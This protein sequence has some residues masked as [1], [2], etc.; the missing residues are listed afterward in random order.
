MKLQFSNRNLMRALYLC[1]ALCGAILFYFIVTNIGTAFSWLGVLINISM[2]VVFGFAIAYFLRPL[3]R[4]FEVLF[5]KI[6]FGKLKAGTKRMFSILITYILVIV[7]IVLLVSFIAPQIA[8]SVVKLSN[9]VPVYINN[10]V[11]WV[12]DLLNDLL[13]KNIISRDQL[14]QIEQ[15]VKN[16]IATIG[17]WLTTALPGLVETSKQVAGTVVNLVFGFMLAIYVLIEKEKLAKQAK[18]VLNAFLPRRAAASFISTM[19]EADRIFG[20]YISSKLVEVIILGLICFVCMMLIGIP[21]AM[22]ISVIF[23]IS[24]LIPMFGAIIGAVP[25]TLL[26]LAINPLQA[27]WYILLVIVLGQFDGNIL[28]PKLLG[29]STGLSALLVIFSIFVGGGL[30]GIL[31]MFLAVPT[32][33]VLYMLFKR[34]VK[35]RLDKKNI[36][37]VDKNQLSF[38]DPPQ[39]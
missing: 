20:G 9:E 26:I 6:S 19:G 31:G 8:D 21:Y 28:G 24:N 15:Y 35:A 12:N 5:A 18:M 3:V 2:P 22:L 34:L 27:L 32:F 1:L 10:V 30:F 16:F 29:D 13:Q 17:D 11:T 7:V 37:V 39:E 4:K 38:D 33:A 23:A 36:A 25:C 14:L